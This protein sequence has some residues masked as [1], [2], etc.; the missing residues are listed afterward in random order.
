[1][2]AMTAL[3]L[4]LSLA[5]FAAHCS[6]RVRVSRL[7]DELAS[8]RSEFYKRAR[9]AEAPDRL[10]QKPAP[11]P[12]PPRPLRQPIGNA[13][14][15]AA[16][17]MPPRPPEQAEQ[18][19]AAPAPLPI[20]QKN[21]H[22]G[23]RPAAEAGARGKESLEESLASKIFVW[24]GGAALLF[25]GFFLIRYSIERGLFTPWMRV[26]SGAIFAT[27]LAGGAFFAKAANAAGRIPAAMM[28]AAVAVLYGDAFAAGPVYGL[29]PNAAA[30]CLMAC[31]SALAF[32][33]ARP[34]GRGMALLGVAGAFLAPAVI[35]S[36]NPSSPLLLTYLAINTSGMLAY[37]SKS[38]SP[39]SA[40]ALLACA[41]LWSAAWP[42]LFFKT[43]GDLWAFFAWLAFA[44]AAFAR[45]GAAARKGGMRGE[46]ASEELGP[47]K[48]FALFS[49]GVP[50]AC[51]FYSCLMCAWAS[52]IAGTG[53]FMPEFLPAIA[54]GFALAWLSARVREYA[55]PSLAVPAALAVLLWHSTG[56]GPAATHIL[57]FSPLAA[58]AAAL[59]ARRGSARF[60]AMLALSLF[61]T[62]PA[63]ACNA[64]HAG[65]EGKAWMAVMLAIGAGQALFGAAAFK[66]PQSARA[67]R[68]LAAS[69]ALWLLAAAFA[70]MRTLGLAMPYLLPVAALF[71]AVLSGRKNGSAFG[72]AATAFFAA[73]FIAIFTAESLWHMF[74]LFSAL[75]CLII[76]AA[77]FYAVLAWRRDSPA[78]GVAATALLA[79]G[80]ATIFAAGDAREAFVLL[81]SL[82]NPPAELSKMEIGPALRFAGLSAAAAAAGAFAASRAS[83]REG[84]YAEISKAAALAFALFAAS[85]GICAAFAPFAGA[86]AYLPNAWIC[87]AWAV[88]LPAAFAWSRGRDG[89]CETLSAALLCLLSA[90]AC[91]F[92]TLEFLLPG[93]EARVPGTLFFNALIPALLAPAAAFASAAISARGREG[94]CPCPGGWRIFGRFMACSSAAA[95]FIFANAQLRFAFHGCTFSGPMSQAEFYGY[96]MVWLAFGLGMLAAGWAARSKALRCASLLFVTAAVLKVFIFDASN[97]DGILR[98]LSFALLG[99]CLIGI[100]WA[101]MRL[102][103]ARRD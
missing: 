103:A 22:G 26:I 59:A 6:L 96:S 3:S 101:Y 62:L 7:E 63:A 78:F 75:P 64:M 94:P 13:P 51:F 76:A 47:E 41:A 85:L 52:K 71:Y 5:L 40:C 56:T 35:P 44:S 14:L 50:F 39:M 53:A 91:L 88:A 29:I 48:F 17:A 45:F 67:C 36:D 15:N 30:F 61:G 49:A 8:L 23:G 55:L 95:L 84:I 33:A 20:R 12:E 89:A 18:F 31:V 24:L 73:S 70:S 37:F 65:A 77:L 57:V 54:A 69:S 32:L 19:R 90:K 34:F 86:D 58:F 60:A 21:C 83:M 99:F 72:A 11:S 98:V 2:D 1:M 66:S 28:G 16:C 38:R 68:I 27:G 42:F 92:S 79:V 102:T 82:P 80:I 97:L 93:A 25:A 10:P 4:M 43:P 9:R 46:I 74:E 87:A 100:G 81:S